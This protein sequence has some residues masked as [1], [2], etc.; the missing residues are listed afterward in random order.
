MITVADILGLRGR[1]YIKRY[2]P[3]IPKHHIKTI[4]DITYCQTAFM[5]YHINQCPD[6]GATEKV[7]HSCRNRNCN[8]CQS[9]KSFHWVKGRQ[10]DLLDVEYF[11]IVFTVPSELRPILR[12]HQKVGYHLLM[13]CAA[14]SLQKLANDPHYVGAKPGITAILHTWSRSMS[15][16]PHV[17]ILCTGGGLSSDHSSWITRKKAFLVPYGSLAKMFRGKLIASLKRQLP[18]V[19]IPYS[20]WDKPWVV[21]VKP[22]LCNPEVVVKYLAR[23]IAKIAIDNCRLIRF[24]N[25]LV[26]FQ[27]R[28]NKDAQSQEMTLNVFEFIRRYLQH[29]LPKAFVKI[30]YYGILHQS[31]RKLLSKT[32]QLTN[33]R[34]VKSPSPKIITSEHPPYPICAVCGF[35]VITLVVEPARLP[36]L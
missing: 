34:P 29:V 36:F 12:Q 7:F 4:K 31:Q 17:H 35:L 33:T 15:Y 27:Y 25:D 2:S 9:A 19:Q 8:R 28:S 11:H 32:K 24:K 6:C 23:Y 13:K 26:T 22:V 21:D 16:H 14:E 3:G 5:G 30:R 20:V 18:D 1:D 10:N